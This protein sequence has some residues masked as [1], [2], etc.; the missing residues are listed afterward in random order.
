MRVYVEGGSRVESAC[1]QGF[2]T[3]FEKITGGGGVI[4]MASGGRAKAFQDFCDALRDYKGEL[5]LLLVDSERPV[6]TDPWA[7]LGAKP[8]NWAKPASATDDQAHLMVEAMEAWFLAD[9]E[10]LAAYYGEEFL[11]SSLPQ[12]PN[13]EAIP[14]RDL[15]PALEHA[16]RKTQKGKYH[17]TQHGFALLGRIDPVK[18]SESVNPCGPLLPGTGTRGAAQRESLL[19]RPF[20]SVAP[21]RH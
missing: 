6:E 8:D 4:I 17:K 19:L 3:L 21:A 1:R 15:V 16:S 7:H 12:N 14:K 18:D 5:V 9:K 2:R 11:A 20:P 10:A 13:V